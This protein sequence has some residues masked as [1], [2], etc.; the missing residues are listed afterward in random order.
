MLNRRSKY[1]TMYTKIHST[2]LLFLQFCRLGYC[3]QY[4]HF[5]FSCSNENQEIIDE[6]SNAKKCTNYM[7]YLNDLHI[8]YSKRVQKVSNRM[9]GKMKKN[10]FDSVK[11]NP[12]FQIITCD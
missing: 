3:R 6:Q 2:T 9:D 12:Q 4:F 1:G 7:L 8:I 10:Q 5:T 11:T